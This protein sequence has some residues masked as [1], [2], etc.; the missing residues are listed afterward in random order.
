MLDKVPP[1][2]LLVCKDG[3]E[4]AAHTVLLCFESTVLRAV[5]K[6]QDQGIGQQAGS[7]NNDNGNRRLSAEDD[8]AG[9]WQAVLP[10]LYP[11]QKP[12]HLAEVWW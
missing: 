3:K 9:H 6:C 8:D 12:L 10:Y 2:I 4:V 7:P 5:L 1:D 11:L